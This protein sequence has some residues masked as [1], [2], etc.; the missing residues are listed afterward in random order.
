M[1]E[2]HSASVCGTHSRTRIHAKA[3][4]AASTQSVVAVTAPLRSKRCS[5]LPRPIPPVVTPTTSA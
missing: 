5:R 4:A 1:P 2:I 3:E